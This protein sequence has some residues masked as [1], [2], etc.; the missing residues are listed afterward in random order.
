MTFLSA[1]ACQ[2]FRPFEAAEVAIPETGLVFIVDA[3]AGPRTEAEQF[4]SS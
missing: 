3:R 1:V 2:D 4:S